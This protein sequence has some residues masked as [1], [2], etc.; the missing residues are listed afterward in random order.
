M[1]CY[2]SFLP[3]E[4][5]FPRRMSLRH[6]HPP[7]RSLGDRFVVTVVST[8]FSSAAIVTPLGGVV[9]CF[10]TLRDRSIFR[11]PFLRWGS[12]DQLRRD[13]RGGGASRGWRQAYSRGRDELASLAAS[14][15]RIAPEVSASLI[16]QVREGEGE[17]SFRCSTHDMYV[18]FRRLPLEGLSAGCVLN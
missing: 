7:K 14:E 12:L 8:I 6:H 13:S 5:F 1:K 17:M 2:I 4:I 10:D 9:S 3:L 11:L 15:G 18:V 16:G